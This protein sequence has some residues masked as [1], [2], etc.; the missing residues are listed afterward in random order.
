MLTQK[1]QYAIMA[2]LRTIDE[3]FLNVRHSNDPVLREAAQHAG[4]KLAHHEQE[5]QQVFAEWQKELFS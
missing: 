5:L 1:Q 2:S 3:F 4:K